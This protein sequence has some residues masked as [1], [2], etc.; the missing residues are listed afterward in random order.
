MNETDFASCTDN[1]TLYVVVNNIEDAIISLQ[2]PSLT[3]FRWFCDNQI[4]ANPDKC[5]FI[6]STEDKV[7]IIVENKKICKSPCE[8][9]LGIRFDSKLGFEAHINDICRKAGL[10]LKALAMIAP[11]MGLNKKRLLLNMFFVSQLNYCQLVCMCSNDTK[12]NK[13]NKVHERCLRVIYNDK[14]PS[15]EELPIVLSLFT[16]EILE[17]LPS[18]CIKFIMVFHQ[19]S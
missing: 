11:Y 14:K 18:K 2:N 4:K 12:N 3:L 16:I 5:H 8:E 7:N 6:C 10:K 17:P 1:N 9:L 15:F 13:I 19:L